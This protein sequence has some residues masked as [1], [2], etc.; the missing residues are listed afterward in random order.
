M[1]ELGVTSIWMTTARS[2]QWGL[3]Q[4]RRIRLFDHLWLAKNST[5]IPG[6]FQLQTAMLLSH[7]E[8]RKKANNF[9]LPT[10]SDLDICIYPDAISARKLGKLVFP[11]KPFYPYHNFLSKLQI[12][13]FTKKRELRINYR[14]DIYRAFISRNNYS[15]FA[16]SSNL[17]KAAGV[18]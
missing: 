3:S 8:M 13:I 2:K 10:A 4:S 18:W 12:T 1:I 15:H 16:T 11:M 9:N 17:M 6:V 5:G 14:E 7:R